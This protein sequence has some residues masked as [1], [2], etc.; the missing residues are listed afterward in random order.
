VSTGNNQVCS[1]LTT[2]SGTNAGTA[3][4]YT[5][6]GTGNQTAL[7][8]LDIVFT[9]KQG[10]YFSSAAAWS[11]PLSAAPVDSNGNPILH[12]FPATYVSTQRFINMITVQ[13]SLCEDGM[14][15]QCCNSPFVQYASKPETLLSYASLYT[16][17]LNNPAYPVNSNETAWAGNTVLPGASDPSVFYQNYDLS[18][19]CTMPTARFLRKAASKKEGFN[20]W[21]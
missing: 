7:S 8:R 1:N 12:Q 10:Y 3:C 19:D 9:A 13:I 17:D 21:F 11:G 14:N 15:V 5:A 18:C 2:A 16:V 6:P 4:A 20:M